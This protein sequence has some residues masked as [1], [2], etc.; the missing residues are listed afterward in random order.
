MTVR[1][2]L[3]ITAIRRACTY[4]FPVL[5]DPFRPAVPHRELC[6]LLRSVGHRG[7]LN[8]QRGGA[9][10]PSWGGSR[11]VCW[12]TDSAQSGPSSADCCCRRSRSAA[13]SS[14]GSNS[15]STRS[16]SSSGSPT[17]ASCRFTRCSCARISRC[18][19]LARWSARRAWRPAWAWHWDRWSA[20]SI[21]DRFGT[22][23]WLYIVS[24]LFGL[25]AAVIML[26]FRP[27][28]PPDTSTSVK[29]DPVAAE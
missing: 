22:Y 13:I 4:L 5:R 25:G 21:F 16:R 8:L 12:A 20:V 6:D 18:R 11:S 1:A 3:T 7:G 26:T 19:S 14:C 2:A 9:F 27:A 29:L 10:R 24:V 23:G 28:P 15:N 17:R